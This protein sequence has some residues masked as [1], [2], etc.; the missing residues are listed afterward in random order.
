MSTINADREFVNQKF[1]SF[2]VLINFKKIGIFR[3]YLPF[4]WYIVSIK[5]FDIFAGGGAKKTA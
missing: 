5:K 1:S 4:F 2:P 3:H